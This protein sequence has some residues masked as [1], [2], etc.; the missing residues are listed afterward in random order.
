MATSG[1]YSWSLDIDEVIQEALEM[2]GGEQTLGNDPKSARR[3]INL[4]LQDWQNRGILLWTSNTTIVSLTTSVTSYDLNANIVDVT[5][6]VLT[7][8]GTDIALTRISMEE[9]LR[10]PRKS[11]TGR[12]S[13]FAIRREQDNPTLFLWPIPINST[14]TLKIERVKFMQDVNKSAG[15]NADISRRFLPAF[16]AGLA[17][18]MAWKRPG[19]EGGRISALSAEYEARLARAMDEDRERASIKIVPKLNRA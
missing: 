1:T 19:V 9:Y 15:Q 3:S 8:S 6:A 13:Q 16:T 11:Q 18:Q 5:D 4:M 14:D 12:P 10:I 7:R 2:I 17:H